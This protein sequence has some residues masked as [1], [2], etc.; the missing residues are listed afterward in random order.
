VTVVVATGA[1][2]A[3]GRRDWRDPFTAMVWRGLPGA[4][5]DALDALVASTT[6]QEH[7]RWATVREQV[8]SAL[9]IYAQLLVEPIERGVSHRHVSAREIVD[10]WTHARRAGDEPVVGRQ[11]LDLSERLG[12]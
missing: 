3:H 8:G 2:P 9:R 4:L 12:P 10:H 5:A 1:T 7:R 11:R 6:P